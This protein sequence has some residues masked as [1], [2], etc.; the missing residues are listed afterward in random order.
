M[1]SPMFLGVVADA[2]HVRRAIQMQSST[3]RGVALAL[4]PGR[5]STGQQSLVIDI[6]FLVFTHQCNGHFRDHAGPKPSSE[7]WGASSAR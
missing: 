5:C 2:L 4:R 1:Y 3:R 6:D 7:S